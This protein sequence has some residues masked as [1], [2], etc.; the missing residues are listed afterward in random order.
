MSSTSN[1]EPPV[2]DE[3][4]EEIAGEAPERKDQSPENEETEHV[5]APTMSS[6]TVN[7]DN[8]KDAVWFLFPDRNQR[9]TPPR[10]L[11]E[12]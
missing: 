11:L 7:L 4:G 10:L 1:K 8:M 2:T 9:P 3:E 6:N 5:Q 12:P